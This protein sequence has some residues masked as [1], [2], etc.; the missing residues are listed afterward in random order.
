MGQA[1][2][3]QMQEQMTYWDEGR[4]G[5][6]GNICRHVA[7]HPRAKRPEQCYHTE[8]FNLATGK[9]VIYG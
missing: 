3:L 6:E 1:T 5:R 4:Q 8:Y 7:K 2:N 9:G